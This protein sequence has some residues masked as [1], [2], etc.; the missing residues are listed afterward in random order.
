MTTAS[1]QVS[2]ADLDTFFDRELSPLQAA[3][4]R[5]HLGQCGRCSEVLHGRMQEAAV[6]DAEPTVERPR[7][8][9]LVLK[10][11]RFSGM[12]YSFETEGD[13]YRS[14]ALCTVNDRTGELL[15][16]S[17]Y[18]NW[19]HRWDVRPSSLGEPSLTAFIARG[20][21]DYLANKLQREGK[22]GRRF[23]AELTVAAWQRELCRRRLEAGR[24]EA[25]RRPLTKVVAR[26]IFDRLQELADEYG[27][28]PDLFLANVYEIRGFTE[29]VDDCPYE[30]LQTE[31]TPE[32]R[33]LRDIVLSALVEACRGTIAPE[34]SA[35]KPEGR[36]AGE[37]VQLDRDCEL[38]REGE[39]A[40]V[41]TLDD[42][43]MA[44]TFFDRPQEARDVRT[45]ADYKFLRRV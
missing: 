13:N 10:S 42:K 8:P 33:A 9:K 37:I 40:V 28:S 32:D 43:Y 44:L 1:S 4:F 12:T 25:G 29:H 45:G 34:A 30:S 35:A 26:E 11:T 3:A 17:D 7:V 18:G 36:Y 41:H 15:I 2:C 20:S 16:S 38:G 14:W 21:V 22:G 31:Q 23:S 19:V 39:R 24:G 5:A 27:E 6:A